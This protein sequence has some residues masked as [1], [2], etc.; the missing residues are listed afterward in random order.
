MAITLNYR[1]TATLQGSRAIT[2]MTRDAAQQDLGGK[3]QHL[4]SSVN[5]L[6]TT[7]SAL[8]AAAVSAAASGVTFSAFTGFTASS[9]SALANFGD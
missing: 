5:N 1:T 2:R 8:T 3:L 4:I 9:M 7:V 6:Q